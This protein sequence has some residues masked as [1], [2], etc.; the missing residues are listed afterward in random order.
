MAKKRKRWLTRENDIPGAL[1]YRPWYRVYEDAKPE[2][3]PRG[4]WPPENRK[5][6]SFSAS[7]IDAILPPE[8]RPKPGGGPVLL[9]EW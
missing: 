1:N 9:G 3:S 6:L 2:R 7:E 5:F 4:Y 8:R